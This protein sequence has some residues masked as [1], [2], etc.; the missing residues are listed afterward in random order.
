MV[1]TRI[2]I[3]NDCRNKTSIDNVRYAKN[4]RD[5]V[6]AP[7]YTRTPSPKPVD[8]ESEREKFMCLHCSY[9]FSRKTTSR[10]AFK[11]PNCESENITKPDT[12]SANSLLDEVTVGPDF[13]M[14]R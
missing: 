5:L 8:N 14:D 4:G 3:C 6:C 13:V 10:T 2:V 11:C 9:L 12:L 1:A 7:C